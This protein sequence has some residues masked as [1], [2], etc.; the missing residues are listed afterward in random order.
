MRKLLVTMLFAT[1]L[2]FSSIWA[3]VQSTPEQAA[4]LY[5]SIIEGGD[6]EQ[7]SRLLSQDEDLVLEEDPEFLEYMRFVNL[8]FS[9]V[10][11]K[12]GELEMLGDWAL[13]E[14]WVVAPDMSWVFT[15]AINEILPIAFMQAMSGEEFSEEDLQV[16]LLETMERFVQDPQIPSISSQV[17]IRLERQGGEWRIIPDD[18]LLNALT[19]NMNAGD[20]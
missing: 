1:L 3:N 8:I 15:Q 19:G 18:T 17:F 11:H 10:S 7:I 2:A 16:L 9:H 6:I 5:F 14:T 13:L 12:F 20:E 4:E